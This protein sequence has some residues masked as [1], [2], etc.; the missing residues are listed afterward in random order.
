MMKEKVLPNETGSRIVLLLKDVTFQ[1][2]DQKYIRVNNPLRE[3]SGEG[4]AGVSEKPITI[5]S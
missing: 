4:Y 3:M 2:L 5:K 1:S